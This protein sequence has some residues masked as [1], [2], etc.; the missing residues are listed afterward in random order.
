[1]QRNYA[2]IPLL[3]RVPVELSITSELVPL[4]RFGSDILPK[5][6]RVWEWPCFIYLSWCVAL[7]KINIL[8]F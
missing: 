6:A 1:V 5:Y 8:Y 2:V 4:Y 7:S 3:L